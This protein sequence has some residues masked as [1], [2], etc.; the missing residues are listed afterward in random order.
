VR[1]KTK[2]VQTTVIT[3]LSHI[4]PLSTIKGKFKSRE[5]RCKHKII[6]RDVLSKSKPKNLAKN[7]STTLQVKIDLPKNKVR[8]YE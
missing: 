4:Y 7:L 1:N 5:E 2:E 6:H 8:V 3:N